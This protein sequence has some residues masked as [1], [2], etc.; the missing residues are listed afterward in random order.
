[1]RLPKSKRLRFCIAVIIVNFIMGIVGMLFGI[2]LLTLGGFLSLSNSPLYVYVLGDSYRP[3]NLK[4]I[5]L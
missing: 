5:N 4:D 1:M 3:S 2:N